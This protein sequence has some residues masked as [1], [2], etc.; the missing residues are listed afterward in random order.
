MSQEEQE[1][2]YQERV[3]VARAITRG[4]RASALA[5]RKRVADASAAAPAAKRR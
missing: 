5:Y 1:Q 3:E 4:R 2:K